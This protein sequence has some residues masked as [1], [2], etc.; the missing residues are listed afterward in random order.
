MIKKLF[1]LLLLSIVSYG[2][3]QAG[4]GVNAQQNKEVLSFPTSPDAYSFDKVGKLPMDLF[5]GKAN[6]SVPIYDI[7][8]GELVFPI[9]LSYN[10]GGIKQN[11]ISSSVGLG[12][13]LSLPNTISKNIL[14]KDD[15]FFP[16]YFKDYNTA[17]QY[18]SVDPWNDNAKKEILGYLYEGMYD[19]QP[20]LFS[21]SLPTVSGSFIINN[22]KGFPI[23]HEDVLIQRAPDNGNFN[24]TDTK[25]N[26][27]WLSGKNSVM[28]KRSQ[29]APQLAVNSFQIDSLRTSRNELIKIE[30]QKTLNYSEESKF[31]SRILT[32][33]NAP[34]GYVPFPPVQT[35]P[36]PRIDVNNNHEKLITKIIFPEGQV[37]FKYSGDDNL[38]TIDSE[39]YRK[40][41]NSLAGVALKRI[42]VKDKSGKTIKDVSFNYSY[43]ESNATNKTYEDYR[44]KLIEVKD[45]LQNSRYSFSYNEDSPLPARNSNNDDYWGYFNSNFYTKSN[46]SIPDQIFSGNITAAQ[47]SIAGGRNRNTNSNFAQLGVLKSIKYPTGASKNLY[48]E[49]NTVET[50]QYST[51]D[52]TES[53]MSVSN[54]QDPGEFRKPLLDTLVTVPLSAFIN[55]PNARFRITFGNGCMNNSDDIQQVH[56]N[57]CIGSLNNSGQVYSSNGKSFTAEFGATTSPL[58]MRL[59]RIG[60][61]GCTFSLSIKYNKQV[62]TNNIKDVGGLRI[63]KVEDVDANNISNIYNYSYQ[64]LNPETGIYKGSGKLKRPFQFVKPFY[65]VAHPNSENAAASDY[66]QKD[67][68]IQNTGSAYSSYSMSNIVTY[69]TVTEYN[70]LGQTTYEFADGNAGLSTIY[71]D[72]TG[73]YDDWRFGFPLKTTYKKGANILKEETNEYEITP[74]KNKLS[75]YN[76]I[77]DN[78]IAFG[79]DLDIVPYNVENFNVPPLSSY[80]VNMSAVEI[81]SGKIERKKSKVTEYFDGNKKI[82][83]QTEN[84]YTDTDINK[85]INLKTTSSTISSGENILTTYQYAHEKGNQLMIGKN[86]VDTPLETSSVQTANGITKTISRSQSIYPVNQGEADTRTSGFVLPLSALSYDLQTGVSST[87]LIYDQYDS[88]G[89]IVQYTTKGGISVS[90]IWG[91]NK[92]KPIAKIEGAKIYDIPQSLIDTI[93]NASNTDAVSSTD[94]SEQSLITALDT[95]RNNAGLSAFQISTYTYDPLIG[96]KSITPPSGIREFYKYDASNRLEKVIDANGKVLKEYQYHYKN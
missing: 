54:Y 47:S 79:L 67:Y 78:E 24:I 28:T 90:I 34:V 19:V 44:L 35:S 62:Q 57:R 80:L 82:E 77:T 65:R 93:V 9:R 52:V 63:R 89:N 36:A 4:I 87:E 27:F 96:V 30:Y 32:S 48:Y 2:Y 12:W 83:S 56:E 70:D 40:D 69:S 95:F 5:N 43:F 13:S 39:L 20:D 60:D 66:I 29:T 14:G 81:Y 25:G 21:Y 84:T 42:I 85:P 15:D 55:K 33:Q 64:M 46:T 10:T 88:K 68:M 26:R 76:T 72:K 53:Y 1:T 3:S 50:N 74:I 22:N 49:S 7:R 86:I 73:P 16:I 91:Y 6:I 61:C 58:R 75:G 92:T 11:E 31:E 17:Y 59:Q 45:N 51:I 37:E 41:I 23:P 18:T 38:S 8:L 94:A 71:T